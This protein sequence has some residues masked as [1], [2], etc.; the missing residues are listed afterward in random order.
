MLIGQHQSAHLSA[1][2]KAGAIESMRQ[3]Q[4]EQLVRG[5][6]DLADINLAKQIRQANYRIRKWDTL[7]VRDAQGNSLATNDNWKD[8]Q[9]AEIQASG[10]A[11]PNDKESA[12]IIVRPPG[13]TTA[14]VSGK[15]NTTG[16]AL[17]E[18]YILPP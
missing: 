15:N 6:Y 2:D 8:T 11:P 17:V 14:I 1:G 13:N 3:K 12:I 7:D 4:G 18:A 16:N 5:L 10:K 9:Q